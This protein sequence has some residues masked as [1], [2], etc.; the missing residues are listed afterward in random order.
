MA[1]KGSTAYS[2]SKVRKTP[3]WARSWA[4]FSPLSLYPHRNAWGNL[5]LFGQPNTLLALGECHLD[6]RP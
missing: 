3:S 1:A 2:G 4:N 6:I 5:H